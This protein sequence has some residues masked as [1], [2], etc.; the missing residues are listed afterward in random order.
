MERLTERT[1]EGQTIPKTDMKKCME[2]LAEYEELEERGLLLRLPCKV[3]DILYAVS[4]KIKCKATGK[5]MDDN[6]DCGYCDTWCKPKPK[7]YIEEH[8]ATLPV[9]AN[10]IEYKD[11]PS[12][13]E[14]S[15]YLTREEAE[16][17]LARMKQK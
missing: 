14:F 13:E 15:T 11:N 2:R 3:G 16:Q 6:F 4:Y 8:L 12:P 1:S 17:E 9:I 7:Y 5:Y 10:L